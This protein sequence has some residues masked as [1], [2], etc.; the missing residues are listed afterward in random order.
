MKHCFQHEEE[1]CLAK[2]LGVYQVTNNK[3][4]AKYDVIV[5]EN[6]TY[7]RNITTRYDLKGALCGR[8][9]VATG[10]AEDVLLDQNFVHDLNVSPLYINTRAEWDLQRAIQND[11]CFLHFI[12]VMDYSLLV[13]VDAENKEFV[14][15]IIDYLTP[16]TLFKKVES[17]SKYVSINFLKWS[18]LV[19]K[20]ESWIKSGILPKNHLPTITSPEE[21]KK[22][23]KNFIEYFMVVPDNW[24]IGGAQLMKTLD[25]LT[26]RLGLNRDFEDALAKVYQKQ[27]RTVPLAIILGGR[28]QSNICGKKT[29]KSLETH[30][31]S[32]YINNVVDVKNLIKN[33]EKIICEWL[34]SCQGGKCNEV[35]RTKNGQVTLR[36]MMESLMPGCQIFGNLIDCWAELLNHEEQLQSTGSPSRLFCKTSIT[37]MY[38]EDENINDDKRLDLF[39]ENFFDSVGNDNDKRTL[40][41]IDLVFFPVVQRRHIYVL[42]FNIKEPAFQI[43][44]N[45]GAEYEIEDK[46]GIMPKK[47]HLTLVKYMRVINHP[48]AEAMRAPHVKPDRVPMPWR[49]LENHVDCGIFTMR[50]METYKGG[51]LRQWRCGLNKESQ[52]LAQ[53]TKL[54]FKYAVRLLLSDIN[55]HRYK[56]VNEAN[57]YQLVNEAT[58]KEIMQNAS[59]NIHE[60]LQSV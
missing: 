39:M 3:S 41:G 56:I 22:R 40:K 54:R 6:I 5:M 58:R 21:Y 23:F 17:C 32:P 49:T 38:M 42:V 27:I 50:H 44:D 59:R 28:E 29:D 19:K 52:Q 14:C 37:T 53:L 10:D 7:C 51:P 11:T 43:I 24:T 57:R 26:I 2:I 9:N 47:L 31:R 20:V 12:N 35:F 4:G 33:D 25:N 18:T 34:F 45:S 55:M 36:V 30:L 46:Y 16:Y 60:R 8:F 13:G 15:G 1:T 48:K